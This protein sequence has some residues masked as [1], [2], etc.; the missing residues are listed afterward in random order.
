MTPEENIRKLLE[1]LDKSVNDFNDAIPEIQKQIAMGIAGFVGNILGLKMP[2]AIAGIQEPGPAGQEVPL[3][4]DQQTKLD[5][6][7]DIL[8]IKDPFIGDHLLKVAL[9]ARDNP[10]KYNMLVGML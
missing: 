10:G 4:P 9:I 3:E 5:Q 2:G 7:L 8:C 1:T 6:A